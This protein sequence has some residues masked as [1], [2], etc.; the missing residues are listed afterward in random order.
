MDTEKAVTGSA[1]ENFPQSD[2]VELISLGYY[3]RPKCL[4][5]VLMHVWYNSAS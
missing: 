3:L 2:E 5:A 1:T 4:V